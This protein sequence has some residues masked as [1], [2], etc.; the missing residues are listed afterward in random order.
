MLSPST[1][2]TAD[3]VAIH[4]AYSAFHMQ[5]VI[6]TFTDS[7]QL[8]LQRDGSFHYA[9]CLAL[10]PVKIPISSPRDVVYYVMPVDESKIYD[11]VDMLKTLCKGMLSVKPHL[12]KILMNQAPTTVKHIACR[13]AIIQKERRAAHILASLHHTSA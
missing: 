2:C 4:M 13:F 3:N 8:I 12:L 9:G 10:V 1:E 7:S 5:W 6:L 11:M